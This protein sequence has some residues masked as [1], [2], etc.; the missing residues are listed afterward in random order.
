MDMSFELRELVPFKDKEY[1]KSEKM[2]DINDSGS[3]VDTVEG[4]VVE[5]SVTGTI[6]GDEQTDDDTS[7][8]STISK[9]PKKFSRK[10]P[11]KNT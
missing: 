10:R 1:I 3:E 6:Q 11:I 4:S 5:G 8:I 9:K 2:S 7:T